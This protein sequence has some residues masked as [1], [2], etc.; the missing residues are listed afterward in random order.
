MG[1]IYRIAAANSS[2]ADKQMA[3]VVCKGNHDERVLNV[4]IE[5][6]TGGGTI[7]LLDGDYYIDG[8]EHED[9]SAIFFGYNGG[10]ARTVKVIGTTDNKAYNTHFGVSIH[11]TEAALDSLPAGATTSIPCLS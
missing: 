6:L 10:N 3:D 7:Q 8:F 9:N 11:V 1:T 5:K 4:W 2:A